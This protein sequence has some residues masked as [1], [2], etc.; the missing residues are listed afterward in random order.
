[1]FAGDSATLTVATGHVEAIE[2]LLLDTTHLSVLAQGTTSFASTG[3]ASVSA[4]SVDVVAAESVVLSSM[5]A[6]SVDAAAD[7]VLTAGA[8]LAAAT[9]DS[10]SASVGGAVALLSNAAAEAHAGSTFDVEAL[11]RL[12]LSA[13]GVASL[14]TEGVDFATL[15]G[16]ELAAGDDLMLQLSGGGSLHT[17]AA[18]ELRIAKDLSVAAMEDVS[19]LAS[20]D[21]KLASKTSTDITGAESVTLHT[22]VAAIELTSGVDDI[23]YTSVLWSAPSTFASFSRALEKPVRAQQLSVSAASPSSARCTGLPTAGGTVSIWLLSDVQEAGWQRVW[24]STQETTAAG[25]LVSFAERNVINVRF[26]ASS[27]GSEWARCGELLLSFGAA[28]TGRATL[29]TESAIDLVAGQAFMLASHLVSVDAASAVQL[30]SAEKLRLSSPQVGLFASDALRAEAEKVQVKV[31]DDASIIAAGDF[32]ATAET[33]S[34]TAQGDVEILSADGDLSVVGEGTEISLSAQLTASIGGLMN[35]MMG[36]SMMLHAQELALG[37]SEELEVDAHI[38]DAV[39]S[40]EAKLLAQ[41]SVELLAED[42]EVQVESAE[43]TTMRARLAAPEVTFAGGR[44]TTVRAAGGS[45]VRLSSQPAPS[46]GTAE[47]EV[48]DAVAEDPET[49]MAELAELLGVPVSRLRVEA[50]DTDDSGR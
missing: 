48:P 35:L 41:K 7:L 33:A 47:F 17:S 28:G 8:S 26:D 1:V 18:G 25:V 3:A 23:G 34:L 15:E 42:A 12:D 21:L 19:L 38:V 43:L 36:D 5:G 37:T 27:E 22:P 39:A 20:G 32:S 6:G 49:M 31:I 16:V 9:H 29:R 45:G 4:S 40:D 14:H 30:H 50:V 24:S 44:S 2:E 13:Q 10:A 11:R 46:I